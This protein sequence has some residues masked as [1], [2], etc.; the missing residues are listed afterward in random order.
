MIERISPPGVAAPRG[1]YSPAVRAGD[2]IFVSGQVAGRSRH[3]AADHRRYRSRNPAG[4]EQHQ[5]T[6][7]KAAAPAWRTS[8]GAACFWRRQG[9][10]RDERGLRRVLRRR[11][12]GARHRSHRLR[13]AG[14]PREIE[15]IAYKPHGTDVSKLLCSGQS[16]SCM[17]SLSSSAASTFA[18]TVRRSSP[19][20]RAVS[21]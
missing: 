13:R 14:H 9:F 2:F 16:L 6:C 20:R 5:G 18:F 1:P 11:Q 7:S 3:P 21:S 4:A 12:T 15:A 8:S 17:R 19:R 10:R